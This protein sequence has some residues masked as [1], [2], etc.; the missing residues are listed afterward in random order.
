MILRFL[1]VFFVIYWLTYL[2]RNYLIKPFKQGY[3]SKEQNTGGYQQKEGDVSISYN[4]EKEGG[5]GNQVGEYVD[6]EEI[7][8][9]KT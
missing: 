2:V 9:E 3:G 6:Y 1:L 7:D 4:P 8:D 5:K